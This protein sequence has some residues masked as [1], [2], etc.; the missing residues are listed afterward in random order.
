M[1]TNNNISIQADYNWKKIVRSDYTIFYIGQ[2]DVASKL[3]NLMDDGEVKNEHELKKVLN[4]IPGFYSAIIETPKI[5]FAVVD[6]IRSYPLFYFNNNKKFNISNSARKVK[7]NQS[8]TNTNEN[9]VFDLCMTGFVTGKNTLY[10]KLF[11][12][13]AGEYLLWDKIAKSIN[14]ESYF[15]YLPCESEENT[16]DNY[17]H[18]LSSILDSI[19]I[20]IIKR[21][22]GAP[23][24]IPLS[25]GLDSR[26]IACKFKEHGYQ[27]IKTFSYGPSGN[28]E[29][30]AAQNIA[31]TLGYEWQYIS[32]TPKTSRKIFR[33]S[34]RKQYWDYAD[35]LCSVPVMND[36]LSIKYLVDTN[37]LTKESILI[38]G[39][40]GDF[41]SGGHIPEILL[42][43]SEN[44]DEV[45]NSIIEKHYSV[46]EDGKTPDELSFR[47]LRIREN[48]SRLKSDQ[49]TISMASLYEYWEWQERQSKL[50]VNGQRVYD[51]FNVK[52]E[53]PLWDM[54]FVKLWQNIPLELRYQQALFKM[55]LKQYNFMNL[56]ENTNSES[57]RWVGV[58]NYIITG[59]N[60][61]RKLT[62][63][64][65][66]SLKKYLAY[67]G[68]YHDQ[69]SLYGY[70][71]YLRNIKNAKVPPQGRG[72]VA[73]GIK[74]ILEENNILFPKKG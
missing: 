71:Y 14:T 19:F 9:A 1:I 63:I 43:N 28:Y 38:N 66:D 62:G 68:H 36:F 22:N 41:I 16:I 25:G 33:S 44:L 60:I 34:L 20:N 47:A 24:W 13:Q 52:W 59:S 3:N 37:Q 57:R 56:F 46:W 18:E 42:S 15:K 32:H 50:V 53:L 11:Q 30:K 64:P 7:Q 54:N 12:I 17:I 8:L 26:L 58:N 67:W 4:T 61:L 5:I 69:Y 65:N 48:L 73:L 51:Y 74:N 23:I 21:A 27:N 39:Q 49:A 72:V 2:D 10:E 6:H 29:A 45:I 35:G 55:Y 40:S 31:R 70:G